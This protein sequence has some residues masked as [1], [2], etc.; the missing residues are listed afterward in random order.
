VRRYRLDAGEEAVIAWA[1]SR[2]G[3]L[4]ILDDERG[5]RAAMALGIP[6]IGTLGVVLNAK[7]LGVIE[8][9]RPVVDHLLSATGWYLSRTVR[10]VALARVG[11]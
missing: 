8:A 1:L 4:A 9:A 3:T 10:D 2:P 6:V 5:R 7:R 11:E